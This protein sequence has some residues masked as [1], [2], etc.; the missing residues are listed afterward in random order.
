MEY[1]VIQGFICA[2]A[3]ALISTALSL[4]LAL[5][6]AY[7]FY[8]YSFAGKQLFISVAFVL[9]IMPTRLVAEAQLLFYG[10][11]GFAG[12]VIA[13]VLLNMPFAMYVLHNASH[14][15]NHAW[16]LIAREYGASERHVYTDI[17]LPFL[18]PTIVSLAGI[19][20]VLCFTSNSLPH[21]LGTQQYHLTPDCVIADLFSSN[22]YIA[23]MIVYGMRVLVVFFCLTDKPHVSKEWENLNVHYS[24]PSDL[25]TMPWHSAIALLF[26]A[27]GLI[28]PC[29]LLLCIMCSLSTFEFLCAVTSGVQDPVLKVP[30]YYPIINSFLLACVSSLGAVIVGFF[31][32]VFWVHGSASMQKM[33]TLLHSFVFVIGTVGFGVFFAIVARATDLPQ[34]WLAAFCHIMLNLP[35]AYRLFHARLT[36]WHTDYDR[37][38]QIYGAPR[39]ERLVWLKFGYL[40]PVFVQALC[41]AFCLSLTEVGAGSLWADA[42]GMT[43]PMAIKLYQQHG[44][45]SGVWGL[46]ILL[47]ACVLCLGLCAHKKRRMG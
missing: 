40:R 1:W 28:G 30:T 36:L 35:F 41:M 21:I 24:V 16:C 42:T 12:I 13:H 19:I 8:R 22:S 3:Q 25:R 11:T 38:A 37:T 7:F 29:I 27:I 2:L 10:T 6:I 23:A 32:A 39:A 33:V 45:V 20:F 17:F 14:G 34:F 15:L 43:L 26:A 47:F 46:S 44:V 4:L 9:S 5:P 31:L 18:W